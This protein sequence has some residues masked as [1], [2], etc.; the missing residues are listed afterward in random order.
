MKTI[1]LF[2]KTQIIGMF[3]MMSAIMYGQDPVKVAP[4]VYKKILLENDAVRVIELEITAGQTIPWHS[5]PDHT[6]YALTDAKIEITD[7]GKPAV[8]ADIKA[9]EVLFIPKVTHMAK[10]I[11]TSSAKLIVTEIK[12]KMAKKMMTKTDDKHNHKH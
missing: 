5:H 6:A 1:K 8:V 3:L 4:D 10:N 2:P 11:G 12:P 7:K 9:G